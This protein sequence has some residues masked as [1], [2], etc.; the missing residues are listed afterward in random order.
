MRQ[1]SAIDA[2]FALILGAGEMSEGTVTI[3]D[4]ATSEQVRVPAADVLTRLAQ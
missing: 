1:A 3:R 2:R 4:L